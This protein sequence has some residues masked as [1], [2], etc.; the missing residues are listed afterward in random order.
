MHYV[1]AV[2]AFSSCGANRADRA[3]VVV[4]P[5]I[6]AAVPFQNRLDVAQGI[7]QVKLYNGTKQTFDVVGVQ[8]LW[9]GLTTPVSNRANPLI[10]GDR[11]DYPVVLAPATCVGD[12]TVAD[13]PDPQKAVVRVLLADGSEVQAPVFDVKY[14]ARKLYLADCQRQF[15]ATQV[16]IEWVN[17]HEATL[18]GRP[19]TEGSLRL[20]RL[21]GTGEVSVLL[22]S[23][24]IIFMFTAPE[25][26]DGPIAVLPRGRHTVEVPIRFVEGRCD[27]HAMAEASQPFAF[28]AALDLGDGVQ[29]SYA[30]PVSVADQVPM[31]QRLE[32]GCTFLGKTVVLGG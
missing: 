27:S 16:G 2:T 3:E 10:A 9:D 7:F 22:M 21:A 29:L 23:N 14:F 24:T 18:D 8:L 25:A 20:T 30:V 4:P 1:I 11:L 5:G 12:G 6:L 32:A 13:M 19:V 17:L 28:A 15:I 31:R 26:G